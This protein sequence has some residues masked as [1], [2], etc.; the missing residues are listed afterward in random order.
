MVIFYA[1]LNVFFKIWI[2]IEVFL[3]IIV[4]SKFKYLINVFYVGRTFGS[5]DF[6]CWWFLVIRLIFLGFAF[7]FV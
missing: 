1:F 3:V 2:L 4:G 5:L 6:V 7:S